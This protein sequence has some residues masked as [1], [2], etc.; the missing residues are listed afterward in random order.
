MVS[1][2]HTRGSS[3]GS[4]T[5]SDN[6][7]IFMVHM[8]TPL[9]AIQIP[10]TCTMDKNQSTVVA[11]TPRNKA[12]VTPYH[13]HKPSHVE[14]PPQRYPSQDP[15]VMKKGTSVSFSVTMLWCR[16]FSAVDNSHHYQAFFPET[17]KHSLRGTESAGPSTQSRSLEDSFHQTAE[18]HG[19][20]L[21]EAGSQDEYMSM[22]TLS[23]ILLAMER[24]VT[25]ILSP[26]TS[27]SSVSS[28]E[29]TYIVVD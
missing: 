16:D 18:S 17:C 19:G 13:P 24:A 2:S 9:S 10:K 26:Q 11:A 3:T 22:S 23:S 4:E 21:E 14:T 28:E 12:M 20:Y 15:V 6:P 1:K 27:R 7:Y 29:D 5:D 8:K 25:Q